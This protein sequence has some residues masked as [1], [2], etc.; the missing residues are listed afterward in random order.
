MF[1]NR[2]HRF[3]WTSS[4]RTVH[5]MT[6]ITLPD[7]ERIGRSIDERGLAAVP[8]DE[9]RAVAD[10]AREL[11]GSAVLAAVLADPAE[12][13]VTRV[14]AFGLLGYAFRSPRPALLAA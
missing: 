3:S 8:A 11:G 10:T 4:V 5:V 1:S 7:L 12:P 13:D 14:R 6:T 2:D 9:L